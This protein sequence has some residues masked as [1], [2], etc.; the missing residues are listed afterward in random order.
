MGGYYQYQYE[1][2]DLDPEHPLKMISQPL[3]DHAAEHGFP[4]DFFSNSY[5]DHVNFG[6]F[7]EGADCSCSY[8][9]GCIFAGC[10]INKC[11]F[12]DTRIYDS[13]FCGAEL[14]MVNFTGATIAHTHF[15][16]SG[17]TF[18]SFQ[19]AR[20]KN[21]VFVNC[22][23][24]IVDFQ[25]STLDGAS[26]RQIDASYI[27]NLRHAVITQGGATGEEVRH[28]QRST[29]RALGVPLFSPKQHPPTNRRRKPPGVER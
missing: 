11:V 27:Q 6:A 13:T 9:Q 17:L 20:L 22:D 14:R 1:M 16:N 12:D 2:F 24:D 8:F 28:L 21:S 10:K 5:F 23:L 29:F 7:P 3:F 15:Q 26:F 25:G 19:N 18:A 4:P